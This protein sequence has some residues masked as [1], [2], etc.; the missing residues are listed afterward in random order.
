MYPTKG[1]ARVS[2][3]ELAPQY[4][5]I[6]YARNRGYGQPVATSRPWWNPR[7]W[8]RKIWIAV[9][10][11]LVI[12]VAVVIAVAVVVSKKNAYPDYST[13]NY[14]LQDTCVFLDTP[15]AP[16]TLTLTW[17]RW[18]TDLLRP[19]QLFQGVRSE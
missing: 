15:A 16:E 9:V 6:R 19:V 13:L 12:V 17:C 2:S 8:T 5:D 7:Y 10:A 1:H 14:K 3:E 18:R 4:E 11:V